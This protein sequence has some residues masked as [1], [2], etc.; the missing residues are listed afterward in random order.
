MDEAWNCF[1]PLEHFR[2]LAG[3]S[4]T[5][6]RGAEILFERHRR[7]EILPAPDFNQPGGGEAVFVFLP[8]TFR[9]GRQV[10][11]HRR[12]HQHPG[13]PG[14]LEGASEEVAIGREGIKPP[15]PL[16]GDRP[17]FLATFPSDSLHRHSSFGNGPFVH[18]LRA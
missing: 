16:P 1:Q 4:G 3:T 5:G 2:F 7:A 18:R 15:A 9:R 13:G 8:E 12:R 11:L 6:E 17:T 14:R 10:V